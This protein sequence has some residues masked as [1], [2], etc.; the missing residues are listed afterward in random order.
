MKV[1][2]RELK[3]VFLAVISIFAVFLV[4]PILMLFW[5]SIW[6]DGFTLEFY[7]SVMTQKNFF[8]SLMNSFKIAIVSAMIA[9]F[10]A[11][12]I[13]YTVHYTNVPKWF[14]SFISFVTTLPMFLPTITYGFAIIYSFG[15][16]GFL[17]RLFGR[18][19]FDIYGF[20]GL[21]V[22][23]VI[24]TIP[25]A[26]LLIH[27]TM[28]FVDKK[29]LIVSKAMSD[30]VLSTFWIAI[31][32]PLLGTFAGALI[33]TFFLCF[34][35]FGI[36]ASVAG[37]YDVIATVLYN[38]M[39]GGIPD[40]NRG[41]VIAMIMLIPSI[42]SICILQ[43]L[44]RFNIRYSRI[45]HA[46]LRKNFT[47]DFGWGFSGIIISVIILSIFAVIFVVPIV[48]EWPYKT[49]FSL[50]HFAEVFTDSELL[51]VYGHTL[52]MAVLT[53]FLGTL[54]AYGAALITARSSLGN[55]Y[56]KIIESIALVTNAIPG[57]VL[58]VAY[59]FVFSGTS[60]QN[61]FLLMILC[62]IVHYFSTSYLMMKNSLSKMN[63]GW[64][65]TAMLMGDSWIKTILRVVTP[66][67]LSSL[68]E[69]F[70]YYF[71]NSMV[72]ISALIFIAGARTMVLTTMIKQLQYVNRFN[73][74]FVLSLLILATNL[75]AKT[76]FSKLAKY[77]AITKNG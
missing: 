32:R 20:T 76:V 9:T 28:E 51:N 29:T 35:D 63:A 45:S 52:F 2:N 69:V 72:T 19:F 64:E 58:G 49:R 11:F 27:N 1:K 46:E 61:T 17:T 31:I 55:G 70:S 38:Q 43:I 74:V 68:I 47:R 40:F 36:P 12:V 10:L 50:E 24:Y 48:E 13:A 54:V 18:Q 23:Y 30:N 16:Q 60:L 22:G 21:L 5:K 44:E 34:T 15:K 56:K 75:I 67:A 3:L 37:S 33:Q 7:I 73:E 66:N 77:K 25:V 4:T 39:L 53:A 8:V 57:M 65:T 6:K 26:F 62:N 71:I 59:L 42:G 14:K 41:A